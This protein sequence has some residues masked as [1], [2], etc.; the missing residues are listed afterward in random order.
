M[1]HPGRVLT[2]P[3]LDL[4]EISE[5]VDLVFEIMVN[6]TPAEE[7]V[8]KIIT[9]TCATVIGCNFHLFANP[10]LSRTLYCQACEEYI[11]NYAQQVLETGNLPEYK[12]MQRP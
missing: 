6:T 3:Q 11:T 1:R 4:A 2:Y 7:R 9:I 5:I 12:T 10:L 8:N